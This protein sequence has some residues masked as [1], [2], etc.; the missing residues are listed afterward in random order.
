MSHLVLDRMGADRPQALATGE[1]G[2]VHLCHP[3]LVHAAQRLK[4]DRPLFL[5]QPGLEPAEQISLDRPDGDYSPVE[6]AI[7]QGLER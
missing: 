1:A 3:F 6:R 5:A 4:S 2:S 7:R